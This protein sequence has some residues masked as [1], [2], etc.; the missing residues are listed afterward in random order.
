MLRSLLT[1]LGIGSERGQPPRPPPPP[2]KISVERPPSEEVP[3]EQGDAATV[4]P[5]ASRFFE[6]LVRAPDSSD[7]QA[8]PPDDRLFL[9]EIMK[10][11][12]DN[13]IEVPVL[14]N[15]AIE[16]SRLLA[17]PNSNLA[18][19]VKAL[20][21]D[22]ALS[23]SILRIA[24]SAFYGLTTPTNSLR[25]AVFR[26]GLSQLRTIVILSHMQDK[27]LQSGLFEREVRWLS[28][29][30]M[31]MA[32]LGQML[33][34]ELGLEPSVAF[35][36]GVL[37]HLEHFL[38][39]GTLAEVARQHRVERPP[40]KECLHQAFYRFG[41]KIRELAARL[42]ELEELLA[43]DGHEDK[44]ASR[45]AQLQSTLVA[46]WTGATD[47]PQEVEGVSKL[48]LVEALTKLSPLAAE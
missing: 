44:I 2:K 10:K 27:V 3:S 19:F 9:S 21:T 36:R 1:R 15:T 42:W 33:A 35:T 24:N 32:H 31:A 6:S 8:L 39:M 41:S 16:I 30:S 22:P 28:D 17:D 4:P 29:L 25:D 18:D 26:I 37:S 46:D 14:P 43:D 11:L 20:E 5:D 48:R 23:V 7:L 45:Y 47:L 13:A 12:R 34:H 40:S 38:I